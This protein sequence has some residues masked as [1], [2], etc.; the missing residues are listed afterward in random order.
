MQDV[1]SK[2]REDARNNFII[3]ATSSAGTAYV[4]IILRWS[5]KLYDLEA[6]EIAPGGFGSGVTTTATFIALAAENKTFANQLYLHFEL[7]PPRPY[8]VL[9]P[10]HQSRY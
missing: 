9:F 1:I 10:P 4:Y 3:V 2:R 7:R 5:G 8:L 6:L